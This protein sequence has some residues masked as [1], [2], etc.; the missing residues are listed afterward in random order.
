[1]AS[2][3]RKHVVVV[4]SAVLVVTVL[5]VGYFVNRAGQG[6]RRVQGPSFR[7]S[8][9]RVVS[10][11]AVKLENDKRLN[12]AGIRAPYK[13][14]PLHDEARER[15]KELVEGRNIRLRFES[16]ASQE[17]ERI[18]GYAFTRDGF[19][20]EILVREG[21]AYVRA[22]TRERRFS[23]TLLEAQKQARRRQRGI[24]KRRSASKESGYPADPKYGN[25]H[26][27]SCEEVGNIKP[28]RRTDFR[29]FREAVTVGFAPC[30]KCRP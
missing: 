28:E 16:D 5:G 6:K 9:T 25:F 23:E 22:T 26:R 13:N 4:A 14:E 30:T 18:R 27:P 3:N 20:N 7:A 29:T 1:M 12:Y 15:N 8:V 24:W 21:L 11:H 2:L 17:G 19:I 10:G